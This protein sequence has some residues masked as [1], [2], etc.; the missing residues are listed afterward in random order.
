MRVVTKVRRILCCIM[1]VAAAFSVPAG[2]QTVDS[3]DCRPAV[4]PLPD[5]S[6]DRAA[7]ARGLNVL[8]HGRGSDAGM[9][10]RGGA[11][12]SRCRIDSLNGTVSP[13]AFD[14]AR[15]FELGTSS[16]AV[17][18]NPRYPR[19]VNDG[20]LWS[21]VGV[22]AVV[23]TGFRAEWRGFE[24]QVQPQITYSS[25][26]SFSFPRSASPDRSEFASPY[27][28]GIDYPTRFGSEALTA[29]DPGQSFIG[30]GMGAFGVRLSNEN[31]WVGPAEFYPI[32]LSNTAPG[33]PHLGVGTRR[34]INVGFADLEFQFVFGEVTESDYFDDVDANNDRQF[35]VV[36]LNFQPHFLPG[37]HLGLVRAYHDST[38]VNGSV[39]EYLENLARSPFTY[40]AGQAAGN[41]LGGVYARWVLK[42]SGFEAY[43]E[44]TR[45][46]A[47]GDLQDLLREPDWTQ[48]YVLGAQKVFLEPG[49][50]SRVY[51]E[52]IHLGS[53]APERAGRGQFSYYTHS[54]LTQGHT[55]RGQLL[56]AAIGPGSDAQLI[57]ADIVTGS[58]HYGG[59]LERVRYDDDTYYRQ[60][61]RRYGQTR[62]DVELTLALS[63]GRRIG[64][65]ELEGGL[66]LSRR[67]DRQF[68][69]LAAT[70]DDLAETNFGTTIGLRWQPGR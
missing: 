66:V 65:L 62:H 4:V 52:L 26:G 57:G 35:T 55:H 51:G 69:T 39:L 38:D 44:W 17:R 64:L 18:Y 48:A 3:T 41:S 53:S 47:F 23:E 56:G 40:T 70:G 60:F 10:R 49:T 25:N 30:Y 20:S 8:T 67:Y 31:L 59:R 21:G 29:I 58:A 19:S 61:A 36:L 42:E 63:Y 1:T 15:N 37:L 46:D 45:E 9:F 50:F 12:A 24:L 7:V 6:H 28:I 16:L 43:A 14:S 22:N 11:S 34:P 5:I 13:L 27:H 2:A 32:V 54:E 68:V 33:F